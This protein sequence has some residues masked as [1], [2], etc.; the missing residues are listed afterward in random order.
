M[1][2]DIDIDIDIKKDEDY[3]DLDDFEEFTDKF[4]PIDL[5]IKLNNRL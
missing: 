4:N 2:V 1:S 3:L 5:E